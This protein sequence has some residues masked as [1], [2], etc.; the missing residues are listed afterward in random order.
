MCSRRERN[1]GDQIPLFA[2]SEGK[3]PWMDRGSENRAGYFSRTA[4]PENDALDAT[5]L[6]AATDLLEGLID[7]LSA[8]EASE[9][10]QEDESVDEDRGKKEEYI[11]NDI[12]EAANFNAARPPDPHEVCKLGKRSFHARPAVVLICYFPEQKPFNTPFYCVIA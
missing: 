8:T 2:P 6:D 11:F 5:T 1:D 3:S 12:G 4:A 10:M 9:L 7:D